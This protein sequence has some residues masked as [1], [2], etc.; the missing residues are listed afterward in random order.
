MTL[1]V[2][3]PA[4][5]TLLALALSC[6]DDGAQPGDGATPADRT[7]PEA[8]DDLVLSFDPG[9]DAVSFSWTSRRDDILRDRA[10]HYDVRY[11]YAFPFDWERSIRI[12][13][14]PTP[15]PAGSTQHLVLIDPSR[16]RDLYASIR[17]VDAA[18]NE[19]PV[20]VVAHVRIPGL[21]FEATCVD[22]LSGMPVAGLDALVTSSVAYHIVSGAD[23]RVTFDDLS[24]G[25]I[26][27]L[28][29]H[30]TASLPYHAFS[31]AF[32]LSDD[33]AISYSM[34]AFQQPASPLYNSVL[35]LLIQAMT[36]LGTKKTI[37][38][39]TSFPI[40]WYAP[41]FV[42]SN[43]LDY[44]DLA[45]RAATRWNV[46]TGLPLFA[47]S[48][49]DPAVGVAFEFLPR[50]VMGGQVAVTE[51]TLDAGGY[52]L[53]DRVKVVDDFADEARLYSI[54]MHE[55]GH[56]LGLQHLPAGFIMYG[57]Q[58]LPADITDDEVAV[59]RLLESLPNGVDL[60]K[61]NAA[62]PTP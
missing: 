35:S 8:V 23:G 16:G 6:G 20:G 54:M 11:G 37:R 21:T 59:V 58:P 49:S 30:G 25:T 4:L 32:N 40:A 60:L 48:A 52:P 9:G 33:V 29:T 17:A 28:L 31:D 51:P 42:N 27:V 5:M 22:A 41:S 44:R 10:D 3:R 34:I 14:P 47:V 13:D 43:G 26:G 15:V 45:E 46:R 7:A 2:P 18:G 1:R 55:L 24:E 50:S 62:P 38:H 57:S 36:S 39:W 12:D 61:Y 19:A 53:H 56:T